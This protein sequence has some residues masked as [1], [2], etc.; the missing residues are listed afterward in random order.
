MGKKKKKRGGIARRE[1]AAAAAADREPTRDRAVPAAEAPADDLMPRAPVVR[2]RAEPARGPREPAFWFGFEVSWAKLAIARV[3]IFGLLAIDAVLQ[4]A[5]APRYG[6]GGFNVGHL[7]IFEAI[8]PGRVGY[9]LGQLGCAYVFVLAM[10]GVATR[11]VLPIGAALYAWLYFG[12]HLDS[13]QH[14]YLVALVVVL[15]CF[16]PW[17][18]PADDATPRTRVRSWALRLILVQLAILYF[19][20]A[21]SKMDGKWVDGTTLGQQMTGSLR[22]AVDRTIGIEAASVSVIV[23]ELA[24]AVM[25]WLP[26]CWKIAAP[27]GIAFH[28]GIASTGLEIGLFAYLMIGFYILIVPDEI[29][30]L[31][32]DSGLGRSVRRNL[33]RVGRAPLPIAATALVIACGLA[34]VS[35]LELATELGLALVV[36]PI[37][38]LVRA[39][40]RS[41]IAFAHLVA[42]ALWLAV[43]LAGSIAVDYYRFWGGSQRRLGDLETAERA[44][45]QLV[46][47]APDEPAGHYQVG[48]LLLDDRVRTDETAAGK[49]RRHA[50]GLAALQH[51]QRLEPTR[52]RARVAEARWLAAQNRTDDAIRK[53]REAVAAEPSHV[54]SRQLLKSLLESRTVPAE[55]DALP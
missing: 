14:H 41:Q 37:G 8:A 15:A 16:V 55:A 54:E 9:E 46:A 52:A 26:R 3:V 1:P 12:S 13:Y 53:A 22:A 48:R 32:A 29:W 21:I 36:V 18:R 44:Y 5:H 31:I 40:R 20:A 35:D 47:I 23:I 19:Y 49:A 25:I 51:A 33:A 30:M 17:E 38:L 4:V 7:P 42:I 10:L 2:L 45:R 11:W 6:A 43:D 50:E 34:W 27:L 28:I 24:L 39:P